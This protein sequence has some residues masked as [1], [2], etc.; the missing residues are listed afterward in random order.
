MLNGITQ[1][2]GRLERHPGGHNWP[3]MEV[4]VDPTLTE[5]ENNGVYLVEIRGR[6]PVIKKCR[7]DGSTV[8]LMPALASLHGTS[9]VELF[10]RTLPCQSIEFTDSI[11]KRSLTVHGKVV[12]IWAGEPTASAS[13]SA[14]GAPS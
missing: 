2:S 10:G 7:D 12:G 1:L 5:I 9:A 4:V 11:Y 3:D 8:C 6:G 14:Q 13:A